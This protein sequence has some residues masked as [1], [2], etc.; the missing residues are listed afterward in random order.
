MIDPRQTYRGVPYYFGIDPVSTAE[1]G[2]SL[3]PVQ[4]DACIQWHC[5]L[6]R[7]R[8]M[9]SRFEVEADF[10]KTINFPSTHFIFPWFP[11]NRQP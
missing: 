8:P 10:F 2:V 9:D 11:S 5:Q 1:L 3:V 6:A 7:I 4:A